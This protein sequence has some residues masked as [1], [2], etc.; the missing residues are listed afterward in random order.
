MTRTRN[1]RGLAQ[2]NVKKPY[3]EVGNEPYQMDFNRSY[4]IFDIIPI[5]APRMTQSDQW[6]VNPEH[7]DPN[8]R[9]RKV[10]TEYF[11]FKNQLKEQ[12][13]IINYILRPTLDILFLIPMPD[14]WSEKKKQLNNKRPCLS[15][16]DTDNL[17]K[18]FM[19]SFS[20]NDSF[21]WKITAQKRWAFL[22]SIIV[23]ED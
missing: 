23:F 2:N 10:V 13:E 12:A 18:A 14:S 16:P 9:Q 4:Y 3:L 19:D 22:G 6:K 17:V 15:T 20:S 8:K 11:Q 5:A 1:S 7:P 21:V